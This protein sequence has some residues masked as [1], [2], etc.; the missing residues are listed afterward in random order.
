LERYQKPALDEDQTDT[1]RTLLGDA[2][3]AIDEDS[4][5]GG[6]PHDN[7]GRFLVAHVREK[8]QR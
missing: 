5:S 6:D 4:Q 7:S 1:V 3:F 8:R 2:D